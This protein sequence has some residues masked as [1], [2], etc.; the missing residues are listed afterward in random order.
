M[1]KTHSQYPRKQS[2]LPL[3]QRSHD[4]IDGLMIQGHRI[5]WLLP[6][7]FTG[8]LKYLTPHGKVCH[9]QSPHP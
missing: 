7:V 5:P 9:D 4:A 6:T 8:T 1:T 3:V 2:T